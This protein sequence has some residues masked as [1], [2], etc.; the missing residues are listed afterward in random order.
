MELLARLVERPG[1]EIHVLTLA[2]DGPGT[3]V[4]AD[5]GDLLDPRARREYKARLDDLS[6][7]LDTAERDADLGRRARLTRERDALEAELARAVGLR[8][9]ARPA[10]SASERARVNVQRRLKDALTRISDADA[11]LGARLT[12]AIHTGTY[13]SYQP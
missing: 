6:L 3:L 9:R 7:E 10:A 12:R 8:G 2:S 5:A 13:C 11:D 4:E 1:E